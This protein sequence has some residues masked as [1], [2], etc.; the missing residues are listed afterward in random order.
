MGAL[1]KTPS[2]KVDS[3]IESLFDKLT[4]KYGNSTEIQLQI[5]PNELI[6]RYSMNFDQDPEARYAKK[7]TIQI[8]PKLASS[9]TT[10]TFIQSADVNH[11]APLAD[12]RIYNE[13]DKNLRALAS[14]FGTLY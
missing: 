11:Y 10:I 13:L 9:S 7:L 14:S 3:S 4:Q 6:E 2:H 5:H 12:S 8:K 1:A